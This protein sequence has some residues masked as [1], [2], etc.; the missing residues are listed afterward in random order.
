MLGPRCWGLMMGELAAALVLEPDGPVSHWVPGCSRASLLPLAPLYGGNTYRSAAPL[1]SPRLPAWPRWL[2]PLR[3]L[4]GDHNQRYS[5]HFTETWRGDAQSRGPQ[6]AWWV[7]SR[8]GY[9]THG[10]EHNPRVCWLPPAPP[11]WDQCPRSRLGLSS[12]LQ[13]APASV[14]PLRL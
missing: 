9:S 13:P 14:S 5:P 10:F 3:T 6:E 7:Q 1:S 4:G 2:L 11:Y 8:C 12:L